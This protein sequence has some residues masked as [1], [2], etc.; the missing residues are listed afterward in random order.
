MVE[1]LL[2]WQRTFKLD[3]NLIWKSSAE[4]QEC[5]VRDTICG[6][7]LHSNCFLV[8]FHHS[9]SCKLPVYYMKL[10]NGISV[11]TRGNFYD[12]KISVEIPEEYPALPANYL[13]DDCMS[14]RMVENRYE[15]ID[16]Y[17]LE[18]FK[19]E[20]A[21][22]GY[23]PATP[24]KKFTIEVPTDE[25]LYVIM[26]YLK[27]AYPETV[28]NVSDDTRTI[29]E[30]QAS[31]DH[32]VDNFGGSEV[33]KDDN[34]KTVY[35]YD[36]TPSTVMSIRD[37]FWRTYYKAYRL[38]NVKEPEGDSKTY[39]ECIMKNPEV[40]EEFLRDEQTYLEAEKRFKK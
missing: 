25:K 8:N 34:G 28:I 32:I 40:H 6:D 26:H 21:Y 29:E 4:S 2:Y 15:T 16:S 19:Y 23:N 13:P 7:L 12:W 30:I 38:D 36:G 33:E 22:E 35:N 10:R 17:F 14:W 37:I 24:A 39:A 5:F 20:W 31:I 27:H 1:L 9:K 11:I 3:S 18:G